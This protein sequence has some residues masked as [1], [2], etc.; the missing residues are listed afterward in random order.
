[1]T[2][3]MNTQALSA[4]PTAKRLVGLWSPAPGCGKSSVAELLL[5]QG[6]FR[7]V[8]FAAPLKRM[9]SAL[10]TSAGYPL[11]DANRY[12][13]EDKE[14]PLTLV[15]GAPTAR[16]LLQTLGTEWGRQLVHEQLWT[17]L[18]K[19]RVLERMRNG[20]AV[21]DDVR[22][23]NEARAVRELGGEL[24]AVTRPGYSDASGHASEGGL[25]DISF[26]RVIVNDGSLEELEEQVVE[27]LALGR[28]AVEAR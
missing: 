21:A 26:D 12:V 20:N 18:W 10:L 14:V 25:G 4:P 19:A 7:V 28:T 13:W 1:M 17:E 27:V 11:I 22:F 24:W 6:G 23:A 3:A 15:P 8:P 5:E 9:V 16:K 2:Q